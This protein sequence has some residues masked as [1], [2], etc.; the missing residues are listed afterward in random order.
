MVLSQPF[1]LQIMQYCWHEFYGIVWLTTSVLWLR[2][3]LM[4]RYLLKKCTNMSDPKIIL[5]QKVIFPINHMKLNNNLNGEK[6]TPFSCLS[7]SG[8][9]RKNRNIIAH[10]PKD[11]NKWKSVWCQLWQKY[12]QNDGLSKEIFSCLDDNYPRY[13]SG[14]CNKMSSATFGAPSAM[15]TY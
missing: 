9:W 2:P 4:T 7:R 6:F 1:N 13:S 8:T 14:W 11:N 15:I 10:L 3:S 12:M 5:N